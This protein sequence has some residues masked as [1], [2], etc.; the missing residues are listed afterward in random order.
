MPNSEADRVVSGGIRRAGPAR[1][2]TSLNAFSF[3]KPLN[4]GALHLFD[5]LD[6][7]AEQGFDA[8]DPT[9]Y[10]FPGYPQVPS[11]AYL[12]DFKR[13]AFTLGLEISGT[14][15][16][17]NFASPDPESRA[18]DVRHVKEWIECAARLGAPVIRV[19]AGPEP[20]GYTWEQVAEWMTEDLRECA[21]HGERFGVV[22][23]VQNHGDVLKTA[24]QVLDLMHRVDHTWLGVVVDTGHF[25][26]GD[27]Y[28]D[29]ARVAPHA[30]NWQIKEKVD[31][32]NGVHRA[33]L[34]R[35]VGIIRDAG[36]RGYLPIETLAVD[37][38]AYDPHARAAEMLN[39]LRRALS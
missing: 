37:G 21:T 39:E 9:G 31:G 26:T 5:L 24:D 16:R 27:P 18:A 6:Y 19:F 1:L 35:L 20:A 29:I 38:E 10:F 4:E 34:G 30:V 7:C 36:Y 23:G 2:K 11:G 14:G 17:N 8:I 22:V 32:K 25:M 3:G 15:V 28:Q 12:N 33:D 13:R